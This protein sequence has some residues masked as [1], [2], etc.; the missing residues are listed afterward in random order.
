MAENHRGLT[1]GAIL[2]NRSGW[3]FSLGQNPATTVGGG[4]NGRRPDSNRIEWVQ[5][6]PIHDW[7]RV[8]AGTFHDFHNSWITELRNAL[9]GG[10]LPSGYYAQ[11]EQWAGS[12]NADVLALH[13]GGQPSVASGEGPSEEIPSGGGV[14]VVEE[15]P[16]QVSRRVAASEAAHLRAARRTLVIRHSSGH[17]VVALLEIVSPANKDRPSSVQDF[18]DKAISALQQGVHVL[19]IDLFPPGRHDPEG[20][21]ALI[22]ENYGEELDAPPPGK[23]VALASYLARSLPEAY[24]EFAAFGDAL[25]SMPLFLD[26]HAY[27]NVPLAATHEAAYRG[28]P[29]IWR[30]VLENPTPQ[31]G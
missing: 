4:Y 23:P 25:P 8:S 2:T 16:P 5:T 7:T 24:L 14:A 9:N 15:A 17:R 29:A 6:M 13:A 30:E 18:V 11:G 19:V 28:V 21:H 22:W 31:R 26:L 27:V 10:L 12:I 1:K 20:I 3:L